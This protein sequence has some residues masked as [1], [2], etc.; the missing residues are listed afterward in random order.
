MKMMMEN[1]ENRDYK[2]AGGPR[3]NMNDLLKPSKYTARI[4]TSCI[5]MLVQDQVRRLGRMLRNT[6][7]SS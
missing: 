4:G 5:N 6:L 2:M 1:R 3:R 7:I